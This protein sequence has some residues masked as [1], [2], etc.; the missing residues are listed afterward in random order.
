MHTRIG[1]GNLV[2]LCLDEGEFMTPEL[3]RL[4]AELNEQPVDPAAEEQARIDIEKASKLGLLAYYE[5]SGNIR[6]ACKSVGV[7][8]AQ[9]ERWLDED[10]DFKIKFA[11]AQRLAGNMLEAEMKRRAVDGMRRY[12]FD[13]GRPTMWLPPEGHPEHKLWQP[14][15]DH[16]AYQG[17]GVQITKAVHYYELSYSDTLLMFM[18]KGAMP[19]KYGDKVDHTGQVAVKMYGFNPDEI[20][21]RSL[22]ELQA[23]G[24]RDAVDASERPGDTILRARPDWQVARVPGEDPLL[25]HGLPGVPGAAPEADE[26]EFSPVDSPDV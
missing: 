11:R 8:L 21:S 10:T 14:P 1:E 9:V 15:K 7:P 13:K 18:A 12:K 6:E 2:T 22:K 19:E 3:I 17:E 24:P 5:N 20:G 4:E 16:P 26:A 25:M 23:G